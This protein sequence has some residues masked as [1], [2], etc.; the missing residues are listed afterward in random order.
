MLTLALCAPEHPQIRGIQIAM[1]A[2]ETF[3]LVTRNPL[4]IPLQSLRNY[5]NGYGTFRFGEVA[6]ALQAINVMF[7]HGPCAELFST[8]TSFFAI[9]TADPRE[10]AIV[11]PNFLKLIRE[12]DLIP[13]SSIAT[14]GVLTCVLVPLKVVSLRTFLRFPQQR[15][16]VLTSG[17]SFVQRDSSLP[18]GPSAHAELDFGGFPH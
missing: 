13:R 4:E 9:P 5:V 18:A 16:R 3:T 8:R 12:S 2:R 10:T 7:R 17:L 15:A 11:S 14:S 1:R 6:D